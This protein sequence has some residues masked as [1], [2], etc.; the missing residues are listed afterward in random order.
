MSIN[1]TN[2][3]TLKTMQLICNT[4]LYFDLHITKRNNF[5]L[6]TLLYSSPYKVPFE[7]KLL[8]NV[9]D[10]SQGIFGLGGNLSLCYELEKTNDNSFVL[11]HPT[12]E[13]EIFERCFLHRVELCDAGLAECLPD[14]QHTPDASR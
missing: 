5:L 11:I 14:L 4:N 3:T 8:N 1:L 9:N 10:E 13:R 2:S 6:E 12:K 7:L